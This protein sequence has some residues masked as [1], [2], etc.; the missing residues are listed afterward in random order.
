[1][2]NEQAKYPQKAPCPQRMKPSETNSQP[3]KEQRGQ[4]TRGGKL[5][6]LGENVYQAVLYPDAVHYQDKKTGSWEEID[7]TLVSHDHPT[8]GRYLSNKRNGD[9]NVEMYGAQAQ[10]MLRLSDGRGH[11]LAWR[12]IGASAVLPQ[13]EVAA[14]PT[15]E[16]DD[17]RRTVLDTLE[18]SAV[19]QD[20]F[21]GAD[22]RC[23]IR[24]GS[25]KDALTFRTAESVRPLE[26]RMTAKALT[27]SQ[28]ENG[29]ILCLSAQEE[30]IF[31]LSAPF[32]TDE[33]GEIAPVSV[34][35]TH[36]EQQDVYRIVYT[37]DPAFVQKA[38]FPIVVDPAVRT[39]N[40][41][42][43]LMDTFVASKKP[44]TVYPYGNTNLQIAKGNSTYGT[45]YAFLK[46][47]QGDLP[48]ISASYYV[49]KASL[50]LALKA[51]PSANV[52]VYAREVLGAW[53]DQTI[54]Y[55][56]Q[57]AVADK[58]LD[59][60]Y[61]SAGSTLNAYH[62]YDISNLVRKW[63]AGENDGL[64]LESGTNT[65][66]CFHSSNSAYYKPYIVINY[67]SLA[68]RQSGLAYETQSAGRAG[69]GQVSLYNGNLVFTHQDTVM[70]GNLMPVSVSHVYNSCYYQ[71]NPFGTGRGWTVSA[72]QY[73]HR[74]V[75]PSATSS[76]STTTYYVYTD[77]TGARHF[78]QYANNHWKDLS[79]L[80]L[81][82]TISGSEA[83]ITDK[84][85]T[86]MIFDLPTVDF[87]DDD[88]STDISAF[89]NV[90]PLKQI[91]DACG[92]T[93]TLTTDSSRRLTRITDGAGRETVFTQSGGQIVSIKE[94]G[95]P[96][97]AYAYTDS[98]L[99]GIT[100]HDEST[101]QTAV[102]TYNSDGLLATVTNIDGLRLSYGY[103]S[104]V[105]HRVSRVEVSR[106][107]TLF[108]GRT[109][110]YKDCL[111]VVTD[112]VVH[113]SSLVEG[114]K[115]FYHFNDNGN[116]VSINDELGY[117]CFAQYTDGMPTNHPEVLSR[118][119][120]SV[121]NL[122]KNHHLETA[123]NW[124]NQ[125]LDSATGSYAH[126]TAYHYMGAKS[127]A[128]TRTNA[129]GQLTSYQ[130]VT[131]TK[132]KAYTFS[133]YYRTTSAAQAK[134]QVAYRSASG[135]EI[136][137]ESMAK[138]STD[139]WD[140]LSVTLT[141]PANSTSDAVTVRLMAVTGAG[142]VYFDCAQLEE[143]AVA[144]PYNM[145]ENGD[146]T[147]NVGGKPQAWS[148]NSTNT[149]DSLVYAASTGTKPEGLSANTMR[150]YGGGRTVYPGIY[151]DIKQTGSKGDVYAAGGW[152]FN[153]SKPRQ[154]QDKLYCIRV[155]FLKKG[156]SST[157]EDSTSIEWS[158]EWTD[159]QFAA[160]PVVAP[161]DYTSIRFNVDYERNINYA[162]FGGLFLYQEE[163]GKTFAYDENNNITSVKNLASQQSHATYD[164]ANNLLTYR[165]P[166]RS[167]SER[168]TLDWGSTTVEKKKHL[169]WK[170]TSP[171]SIIQEN[172]Y[173]DKG[174]VLTS[175]TRNS[176]STLVIQ[177]STAYT[178]NQNYIASQTDARGNTVTS[179]YD[180]T[181]GTLT[182]VVHPNGRQTSY[183]Y[184]Q[185]KRIVKAQSTADGKTYLSEST[186]SQDKLVRT[187]H[188][189]DSDTETSVAYQFAYDALGRPTTVQVGSQTLSTT[190]YND[191]GTVSQIV[192]G[193]DG[194]TAHRVRYAYD[195][196]KRMTGVQFG[197]LSSNV[198]TYEYGAN[199]QVGRL[200]DSILNRIDTSEYDTANRPMR[201]TQMEN[202]AHL[203]TGQVQYDAYNNLK[204]FQEKVGSVLTAYRTDFTYDGENKPTLLTYGD[205]N[206]TVAYTY[207]GI[208]RVTQRTVTLGGNTCATTYAYLS[209]NNGAGNT[210]GLLSRITYPH[211]QF[212]YSYDNM[213]NITAWTKDDVTVTYEYDALGQLI[214][215]NDPTDTRGGTGTT[216]AF[217]YDRGGNILNKK[218]YAYTTGELGVVQQTI[219]YAYDS[220]WKD[221]LVNY[222]G[223]SLTYDT[224]GNPLTDGTWIYT[225]E[226]G[227]QLKQMSKSD[228]TVVFQYNSDGIRV[229]KTVGSTVTNYTLHGKH[230]V[231]MAAGSD[232]LHFF[233]DASG[234]PAMVEYNGTR[235]AYV[236]DLQGDITELMDANGNVVVQYVYDSWGKVLSVTGSMASTLGT[237]Q[238]FRY[239]G[240]VYDVE[241][242]LYYLR[243]RYYHPEV[244]RFIN[245][246]AIVG[247]NLFSYCNDTP[248][249]QQD[250]EGNI[251]ISS[252]T[253]PM[254]GNDR[255]PLK[256][257]LNNSKDPRMPM[258]LFLD[259]LAQMVD[260]KWQYSTKEEGGISYGH[261]DCAGIYR[262]IMHWYFSPSVNKEL[263]MN[264]STVENQYLYSVFNHDT[265]TGIPG[266]GKLSDDTEMQI[267][268]ALFRKSGSKWEHVA[269]YVG[270]YFD[271][272][273]NAV[274]EAV[275]C[276]D[277]NDSSIHGYVL[278][279]ELEESEAINGSFTHYG[280]YKGLAYEDGI[281]G[282]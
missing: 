37:V 281:E 242:G 238:P 234:K 269:I 136:Q 144:N 197:N 271:G 10:K 216:W 12:F 169:L 224:I 179:H 257:I 154:G 218:R 36:T 147:F 111:T 121:I 38:T 142:V 116:V 14:V 97:V 122:L 33:N 164:D 78:F 2:S 140:R 247:R 118:M 213:G 112:L 192:Y 204:T 128:M 100:Y 64:R 115:L 249:C 41:A 11:E 212:L 226:N 222:N 182:S 19:Y 237:V 109:Y 102:Y 131:V 190:S 146:F 207:D 49:T 223:A 262:Y 105:P 46:F 81:E 196:F 3:G 185:R 119:Q 280:Y 259:C 199:G 1:M 66:L 28:A 277:P 91:V 275:Q 217:E 134:L 94:P 156:T 24:G 178:A 221:K 95:A 132:G 135:D 276:G 126:T 194:T 62:S 227:R 101:A 29:D 152:S 120:R 180:L 243:S 30:T 71:K 186:Y 59:Y 282:R 9:L 231:H 58:Y 69:T 232:T 138:Q 77:S 256:H 84:A 25:F 235:Y 96:M 74:E 150:L 108:G 264:K 20:L 233:Y 40:L 145:L 191:D 166:G 65:N 21:P 177:G 241:T 63:Y 44:D 13:A 202:G 85:D 23:V 230:I 143:G 113:G 155:A 54:T 48:A 114:K 175:K 176:A 165:Q 272:Y 239:R 73:L 127:L 210:T 139:G 137:T 160:G 265:R 153:Y 270:D 163:F 5:F 263:S 159:W 6:R 75:L 110:A 258:P 201:K 250:H 123:N 151:Q 141:V 173:D 268:M 254:S 133:A 22:L 215:V 86:R 79:G 225:W 53:S 253:H 168:Y 34:S 129:L 55:N 98:Q 93:A 266:K 183:T 149:A 228:T 124:T 50:N 158:K 89:A 104:N 103:T 32:V 273:A 57:P 4:R 60:V 219:S 260:E 203:Y 188:N 31:G 16:K 70:N 161:C 174:N 88:A 211:T 251:P 130:A 278:I 8:E 87:E 208:G 107:G 43:S 72:Q 39:K 279:R 51:R 92:N 7:N 246:D 17:L 76:S 240:Y 90:K 15:H 47:L 80:S 125:T 61:L 167:T 27:I 209:G 172:T 83:T 67:V 206:H 193:N 252:T 56:N 82:L 106:H 170:I 274:V 267:G 171:L 244:G 248:I 52:V 18:G 35:L 200:T 255:D 261:T 148:E 198:Y 189:T 195:A 181:T 162:E 236:H 117:G 214:R 99:T 68:G 220:T 205:T 45:A 157:R 26:M 184:D 229:R 42:A 245:A 187:A